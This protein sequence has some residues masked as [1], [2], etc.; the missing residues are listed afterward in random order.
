MDKD[1]IFIGDLFQDFCTSRNITLQTVIPG[2]RQS[3]GATERRHAH[4]RGIIDHIIGNR[5]S[6]SL[7]SKEWG[8]FSAMAALH[9]NSQ[10]Q[11]YD[12]FTP[13][14]RAFWAGAEITDWEGGQPEFSDFTKP[15]TAPPRKR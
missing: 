3:L 15:V 5:K 7:P 8:E 2:H 13:R 14:Q 11:Q 6:N 1:K 12:G 9:L 4:F 10:V